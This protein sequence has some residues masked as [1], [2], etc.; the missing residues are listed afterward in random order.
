MAQMI[1]LQNDVSETFEIQDNLLE[2]SVKSKSDHL[3][4][5]NLENGDLFQ[6][7]VTINLGNHQA[8]K[9]V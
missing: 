2:I 8:Q 1:V 6:A 3:Y 9:D 4:D 5:M 7:D